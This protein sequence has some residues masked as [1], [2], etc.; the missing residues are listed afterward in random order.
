MSSLR[1][2]LFL[3]DSP[4]TSVPG[5]RLYRRFATALRGENFLVPSRP[6][7]GGTGFNLFLILQ[8]DRAGDPLFPGPNRAP[9]LRMLGQGAGFF[10]AS[11]EEWDSYAVSRMP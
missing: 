8:K 3:I 5:Y 6:L 11:E 10:S 2:S 7:A 1:D 4:G 9:V